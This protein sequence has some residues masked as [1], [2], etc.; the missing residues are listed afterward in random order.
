MDK[1]AYPLFTYLDVRML[2]DRG[3]QAVEYI[4]YIEDEDDNDDMVIRFH[5]KCKLVK[6][7]KKVRK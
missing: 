1:G 4:K 6:Q 5:W 7:N 2:R 3:R